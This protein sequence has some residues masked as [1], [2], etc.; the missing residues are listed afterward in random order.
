MIRDFSEYSSEPIASLI[1]HAFTL[2]LFS[3]TCSEVSP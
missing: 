3:M 2:A 1:R